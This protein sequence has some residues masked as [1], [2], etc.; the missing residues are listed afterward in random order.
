MH[1]ELKQGDHKLKKIEH[2][3]KQKDNEL[4]QRHNECKK[5]KWSEYNYDNDIKKRGE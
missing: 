2:E 5:R 1:I 4:V 3:M